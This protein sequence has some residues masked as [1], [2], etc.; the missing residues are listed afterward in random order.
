MEEEQGV[1][2]SAI[3]TTHNRCDL[4]KRAIDSAT[5]QT[6]ASKEVIVV[7]DASTDATREIVKGIPLVRY[8]HIDPSDSKGGN[9]ARNVGL[10][11]ARGRYVAFLDDDDYWMPD[12][13]ESQVAEAERSGA[14]IVFCKMTRELIAADGSIRF[15]EDPLAY[16]VCGWPRDMSQEIF[17]AIPT[18]TSCVLANREVV[19]EAGQFDE[20]LTSWQEY[21]L[22]IRTAQRCK[23]SCVGSSLVVYRQNIYDKARVS[24]RFHEWRRTVRF[25]EN[26]HIA[27]IRRLP[28]RCRLS[29]A[30][31]KQ[32]DAVG[33]ARASGLPVRSAAAS[34]A[35]FA[36]RAIRKVL[37]LLTGKRLSKKR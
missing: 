36:L 24:N 15:V 34:A 35:N 16:D 5:T 20:T 29:W 4:L 21:E 27:L 30:I 17:C 12:K 22:L 6:I 25:V 14:G 33:R 10:L 3:I 18:V 13:L 26:K 23:F 19:I 9:H 7:D 32:T 1:T 28:L 8:I 2:V 31:V 11:A 37:S